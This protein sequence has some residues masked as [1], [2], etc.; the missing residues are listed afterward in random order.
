MTTRDDVTSD[1]RVARAVRALR[2]DPSSV[3]S[4]AAVGFGARPSADETVPTGFDAWTVALFESLV[5]AAF[6]VAV[7]DGTFDEDERAT[8][9]RVVALACDGAVAPGDLGSLLARLEAQLASE[10][11]DARVEAL[12]APL[13]RPEHGLE[14]LRVA[15]LVALAS[16]G[17]SDVERAVLERLAAACG[18]PAS[19]VDDVVAV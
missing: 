8:F 9:E 14:V 11:L 4:R 15:G 6:L 2:A 5:E 19:R 16:D 17:V 10:G 12:A 18:L 7:A 13:T 3:L 1:D